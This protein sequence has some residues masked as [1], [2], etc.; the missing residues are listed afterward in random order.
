M[1][2]YEKEIEWA[3]N[4]YTRLEAKINKDI[5]EKFKE[6]LKKENISYRNWLENKI[7]EE[8]K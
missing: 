2:H 5:G 7:K 4:K 3:K 1:R 6:H 8:I